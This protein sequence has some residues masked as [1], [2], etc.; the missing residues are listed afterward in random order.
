MC[1][2]DVRMYVSTYVLLAVCVRDVMCVCA[3][4]CVCVSIVEPI[5]LL[6]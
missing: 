1:V 5:Q 6:L 2:C 3:C 4:L